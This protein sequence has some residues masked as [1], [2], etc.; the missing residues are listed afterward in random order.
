[1]IRCIRLWT[2][3][4]GDSVFETGRLEVGPG[5]HGK[6]SGIPILAR[7]LSFQETEAPASG[8]WHQD[9]LPQFVLMLSGELEFEVRGG[10]RFTL[11]PGD[12]LIAQDNSGS[13]HRWQ[14][15]GPAPWRRAYVV[16]EPR[17]DLHFI[18][19]GEPA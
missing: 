16:Y 4:E 3:P 19:D 6:A 7:E 13:G 1:M 9:P 14:L 15:K 5:Q 17:A 10:A 12:V 8:E 18:A 2:G 11:F